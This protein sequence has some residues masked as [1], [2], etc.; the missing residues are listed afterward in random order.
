MVVILVIGIKNVDYTN[1]FEQRNHAE[2]IGQRLKPYASDRNVRRGGYKRSSVHDSGISREFRVVRD[3]RVNQNSD[4]EA[5]SSTHVSSL[6]NVQ[7]LNNISEKS[8][9]VAPNNQ[10]HW[11]SRSYQKPNGVRNFRPKV[12]RDFHSD[13]RNGYYEKKSAVMGSE[14]QDTV[15]KP[16]NLHSQAGSNVSSN[17]V[18]VYASASDP[19]HVPSPDSRSPA[20][21]SVIRREVGVVGSR[22]QSSDSNSKQS[23]QQGSINNLH[24]SKPSKTESFQQTCVVSR[25][26]LTP[27]TAVESAVVSSTGSRSSTHFGT[28]MH[29]Q[30]LT[31]QKGALPGKEWKPKTNQKA[32][33][34]SPGVIGS[35]VKS[36]TQQ[37]DNS[38]ND[39]READQLKDA[40]SQVNIQDSQNVIIA[41]HIRVPE[42]DRCR[43]T[44]GTFGVESDDIENSDSNFEAVNDIDESTEPSHSNQQTSSVE[45]QVHNSESSSPSG[46]SSENQSPEKKDSCGISNTDEFSDMGLVHNSPTLTASKSQQQQEA[47]ELPNFSAYDQQAVYDISYFRPSIDDAVRGSGLPSPQEVISS[48]AANNVVT[49]S[50]GIMQQQQAPMAQMYPPVHVSHYAMQYRQLIPPVY[51]P[52]MVPGF[53]GNPGYPHL[54]NGSSYVLMPGGSS[55]LPANSLKYGVQQFKPFPVGSP[56]GFGNLANPSGYA[57]NAPGVVGGPTSLDDSSRLKYKDNL[58]VPNPQAETSEVWIQNHREI[59]GMQ[60]TPY[61]NMQGQTAHPAAYLQSHTG[62]ASF[63][64]S[65]VTPS[66]Q[67]QFTGMY[68]P[69]PAGMP[70]AHHIASGNI[71]VGVAPPTPGAQVGTYQQPQ[72]SHHLNWTANF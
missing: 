69:Q 31:H 13:D 37:A 64:G 63:N 40:F 61:F 72:L 68:P 27:A 11:G 18:G 12:A 7:R 25:N 20:A 17:V 19:V 35:P 2:N 44:F 21:I 62:H 46:G 45:D 36:V 52:P 23:L 38:K 59:P 1:H 53:S 26:D 50:V 41:K 65:G 71:G 6:D 56:A 5:K 39:E 22:R 32:S 49:S 8:S 14:S 60:S 28:R 58:Y 33:V 51:V 66:S 4:R 47:T 67:M 42:N 55:H 15:T 34:T 24:L 48:Q 57:I 3:N 29:Q 43:L 9:S 54:S 10:R 30:S 16:N 70:N